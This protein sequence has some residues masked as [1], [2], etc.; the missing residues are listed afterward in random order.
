MTAIRVC[1][2]SW[3]VCYVAASFVG[4]IRDDGLPASLATLAR[5]N[6]TGWRVHDGHGWLPYRV[7]LLASTLRDV[8]AMAREEAAEG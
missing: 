2:E 8:W 4:L 1:T 7:R 5:L 3:V 6:G